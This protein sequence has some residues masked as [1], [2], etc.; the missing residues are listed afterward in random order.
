MLRNEIVAFVKKPDIANRLNGLG[1]VPGGMSGDAIEAMFK[2][3][4]ETFAGVI[5]YLGIQPNN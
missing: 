1:I 4:H 2:K 3:E 5:K